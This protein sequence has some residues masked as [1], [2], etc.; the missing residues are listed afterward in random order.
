VPTN[1]TA[2]NLFLVGAASFTLS[3]ALLT[4]DSGYFEIQGTP[5]VATVND[6]A[7]GVNGP[8]LFNLNIISPNDPLGYSSA[9]LGGSGALTSQQ[10]IDLMNGDLYVN[11]P[12][13]TFPDGELRGQIVPEPSTLAL[14]GMSSVVFLGGLR[15]QWRAR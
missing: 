11:V 7:P 12:S 10:I 5:T 9:L 14:L 15:R 6:G 13:T 1:S 3:G 8:A 2:G 4:C